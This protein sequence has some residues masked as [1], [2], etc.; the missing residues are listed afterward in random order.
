MTSAGSGRPEILTPRARALLPVFLVLLVGLVVYQ[1]WFTLPARVVLSGQTMGTTWSV[2]LPGHG[3]SRDDLVAARTA[4]GERLDAVDQLMSTWN[5]DSELSRLNRHATSAPFPVS[6]ET[7]E[8]LEVAREVSERSGGAFDVT[9]GPLVAAWGFGAGARLPGE[10]PDPAELARIRERV[11]YWMLEID[12]AHGRVRKARPDLQCDL[13]AIAKGYGVDEVARALD[14]LG[15]NDYLVEVGGEVRARGERPEGGPWH[16]G[17]ERPDEGDRVVQGTVELTDLAMATS[18]D[19]RNYYEVDG[20]RLSHIIDPRT[21]HPV[22]HRV[23]S[24]SVVHVATVWADAW[25]T[26]LT[27]L[28]PEEGLDVAER[29]GIGVYF[30]LRTGPES[31]EARASSAF[32]LVRQRTA[33]GASEVGS[34]APAD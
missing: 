11:G 28:G 32:P 21:G 16:V 14:S 34:E 22:S 24:V 13:S 6:S 3:H 1:L 29:E 19:Y 7:L 23:A 5:S 8:V 12:A 33:A 2:V 25:A 20:E 9:V 18:G 27:V 26:A 17:I 30:L 4:I 10:V 15:W 31:F